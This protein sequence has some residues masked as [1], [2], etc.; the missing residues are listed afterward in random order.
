ML[1]AASSYTGNDDDVTL[2]IS[3]T[4]DDLDGVTVAY[5]GANGFGNIWLSQ[6]EDVEITDSTI[7]YSSGYGIYRSSSSVEPD[8]VTY[9][10]NVGGDLY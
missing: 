2:I 9:I 4:V 6:C 3:A 7:S 8:G 5:G 10:D 1:D